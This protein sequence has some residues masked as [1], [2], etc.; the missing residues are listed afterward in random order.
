MARER[1]DVLTAWGG[2]QSHPTDTRPNSVRAQDANPCRV[3]YN[4]D[5]YGD[6]DQTAERHPVQVIHGNGV[7]TAEI[8]TPTTQA[9]LN[10]VSLVRSRPAT[11]LLRDRQPATQPAGDPCCCATNSGPS[12]RCDETEPRDSFHFG[13]DVGAVISTRELGLQGDGQSGLLL[14]NANNG[15]IASGRS[16]TPLGADP[17]VLARRRRLSDHRRC[18]IHG[19]PP[20]RHP[21]RRRPRQYRAVGRLQNAIQRRPAVI[22][23]DLTAYTSWEPGDVRR[24]RRQRHLFRNDSG[25]VAGGC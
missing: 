3:D 5:A 10:T 1:T 24:Q 7:T 18:R 20:G 19:R 21:V 13:I 11:T 15:E 6:F 8:L 12:S 14:R 16:S 2:Q 4:S 23:L 17:V 9:C 22:V 25:Q